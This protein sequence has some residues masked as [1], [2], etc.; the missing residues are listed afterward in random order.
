MERMERVEVA[1]V[2]AGLVGAAVAYDLA[3]AGVR[4]VV[5]EGAAELAAGASRSNSG[6]VH[7]G[8]D[9]TPGT[10]ETAMIRDQ[11]RRWRAIFDALGVPY[12]VPGALV[13]ATDDEQASRLPG[14]AEQAR[15]NGVTVELLDRAAAREREPR[16]AA[17][18][19]LLV[20]GEAMTDPY[21]V[22]R[23]CWPFSPSVR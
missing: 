4:A 14:L 12:R 20:P 22:V 21:E 16:V 1:V 10:L 7:T 6:I 8:F 2:G 15:G 18:A 3:A 5:L 23:L 13:I 19:A 11:A 17:H 9:S